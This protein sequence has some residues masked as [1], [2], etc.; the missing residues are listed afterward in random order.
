M[1]LAKYSI[2]IIAYFCIPKAFGKTSKSA[3][4]ELRPD[5]NTRKPVISY[6]LSGPL[7][8]QNIPQ[9][10]LLRNFT[11]GAFCARGSY[12]NFKLFVHFVTISFHQILNYR[13]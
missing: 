8:W 7:P 10:L 2:L 11:A 13:I 9:T 4:L 3:K 5:A 1:Y 12:A 6:K